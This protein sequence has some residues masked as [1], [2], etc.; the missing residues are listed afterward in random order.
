MAENTFATEF[1]ALGDMLDN[2][3]SSSPAGDFH[4]RQLSAVLAFGRRA[5]AQPELSVLLQDA[6]ALLAEILEVE[7]SGV[8]RVTGSGATLVQTIAGSDAQGHAVDAKINEAPLN[9][10]TSMAG[11]AL[12]VAS[13]IVA[14]EMTA[15]NRFTDLFLR[16]LGV[17]SALCVP[18]HLNRAAFGTLGV[19][20]KNHHAFSSDDIRF[21]ETMAHLVTSS[22]ARVR[23]EEALHEQLVFTSRVM[24]TVASLV[25]VL[26]AHGKLQ[27]MNRSAQRV[28]GFTVET[29]R[30]KSFFELLL[31]PEEI[32]K[33]QGVFRHLARQGQGVN[34][35]G[36]MLTKDGT[37][38]HVSWSLSTMC[39]EQGDIRSIL[40]SG[41]DRTEQLATK[42]ALGDAK[43]AADKAQQ[44]LQEARQHS[45]A[46]PAERTPDVKSGGQQDAAEPQPFR[47]LGGKPG[48]EQRTS[49][50][51]SYHYRQLIAPIRDGKLPSPEDFFH[52][53]C[54]DISAGGISFYQDQA[55]DFKDLVVALGAPPHVTYFSAHIT[56]VAQKERDGRDMNFVGC[57]FTGRVHL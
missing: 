10:E 21:A 34:I 15:E 5:S 12:N 8:G 44:A 50:R 24:G 20:S 36:K 53:T 38:R 13:P 7:L 3:D 33:F 19:Y 39:N 55:P 11:Y 14:P 45:Q 37:P 18:L 6:V 43:A 57:R 48:A 32:D 46:E 31:P 1:N 17:R 42:Q 35:E 29:V 52:V 9:S 26:D 2:L 40:L 54:E 49:P 56:R 28:T 23:A 30:G 27:D 25:L 22:I 41:V 16:S 4:A 47:P 51:R